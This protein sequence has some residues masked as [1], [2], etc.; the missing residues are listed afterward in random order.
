[1][2]GCIATFQMQMG[3]WPAVNGVPGRLQI[4]SLASWA[5]L[6]SAGPF[7]RFLPAM[8]STLLLWAVLSHV[9]SP[10]ALPATLAAI[11]AAFYT[12]LLAAGL[13]LGDAQAAGWVPAAAEVRLLGLEGLSPNRHCWRCA[14]VGFPQ[15][16]R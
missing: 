12:V 10:L 16:L 6:A 9:R 2:R 13:S 11:P 7:I 1:M 8:G 4:E 5:K 14:P 3:P 15:P